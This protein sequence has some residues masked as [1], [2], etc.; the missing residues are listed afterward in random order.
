MEPLVQPATEKNLSSR[1]V[2]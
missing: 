1:F 2:F